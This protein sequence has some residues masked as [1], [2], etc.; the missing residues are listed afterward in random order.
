MAFLIQIPFLVVGAIMVYF[1]VRVPVE[2]SEK[3]ALKRVDY[4]GSLSLCPLPWFCSCS[5]SIR[6]AMF[7]LGH[8]LWC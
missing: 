2:E 4:L 7:S 1:T 8:T 6:G 5:E 3:S